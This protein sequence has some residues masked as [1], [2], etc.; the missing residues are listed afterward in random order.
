[1]YL[2]QCTIIYCK[3]PLFSTLKCNNSIFSMLS[4][5]CSHQHFCS[6]LNW[7]LCMSGEPYTGTSFLL[8]PM[9]I[10]FLRFYIFLGLLP[11][12]IQC[13]VASSGWVHE[14][15][16]PF[17]FITCP[18]MSLSTLIL[19]SLAGYR[20]LNKKSVLLERFALLCSSI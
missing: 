19:D 20:I 7:L 4:S 14:Q 6:H 17:F 16:L 18:K 15:Y 9:L 10:S 3:I 2:G 12:S 8:L 13:L 11:F 5:S 1:M